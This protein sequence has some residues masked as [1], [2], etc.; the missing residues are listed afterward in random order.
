MQ[1]VVK[2]K[3]PRKQAISCRFWAGCTY[4]GRIK[5]DHKIDLA[6]VIASFKVIIYFLHTIKDIC[7]Y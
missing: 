3:K 4:R 1:T 6:I 7:G 5:D 2:A